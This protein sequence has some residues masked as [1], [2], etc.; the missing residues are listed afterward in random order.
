MEKVHQQTAAAKGNDI[1]ATSTE[2]SAAAAV[3]RQPIA[4]PPILFSV[5]F[6]CF[7]LTK[8]ATDDDNTDTAT[9]LALNGR[10]CG[11]LARALDL[12]VFI[13]VHT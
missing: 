11:N 13:I 10:V 5:S 2:V 8:Q 3:A 9:S 1:G 6:F 4:W 12:R 7:P